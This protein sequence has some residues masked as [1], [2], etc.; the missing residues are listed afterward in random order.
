MLPDTMMEEENTNS[1]TQA[2]PEEKPT[3]N[4][5]LEKFDITFFFFEKSYS[6]VLRG[7]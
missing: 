5:S 4:N 6:F 3:G 1:D 2:T 7:K